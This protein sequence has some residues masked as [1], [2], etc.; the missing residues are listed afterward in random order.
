MKLGKLLKKIQKHQANVEVPW[1][2]SRLY[3]QPVV[4]GNTVRFGDEDCDFASASEHVEVLKLFLK[5]FGVTLTDPKDIPF[6]ISYY[7]RMSG[8]VI[9]YPLDDSKCWSG[10]VGSFLHFLTLDGGPQYLIPPTLV[11][12]IADSIAAILEEHKASMQ[13]KT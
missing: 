10:L 13:E 2:V 3:G 7:D 11:Q 4:F 6:H 9:V 5:E 12:K 8:K 1:D